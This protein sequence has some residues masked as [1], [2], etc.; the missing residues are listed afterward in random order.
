M[1]VNRR[2]VGIGLGAAAMLA[3]AAPGALAATDSYRMY[4]GSYT[5]P[6]G[7]AAGIV[8]L[9][10]D[11][12]TGQMSRLSETPGVNP[13]WLAVSQDR[14]FLYASNEISDFQTALSG[15]ATAY[16]IAPDGQ[17]QELNR[18]ASGGVSP[19]A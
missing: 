17:L 3:A 7:K 5:V 1:P 6:K 4:V 13:S 10:L 9:S 15:S 16:A 19:A 14:R 11:R 8:C 2:E 18:Q 12:S